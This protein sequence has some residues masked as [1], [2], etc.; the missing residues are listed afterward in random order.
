MKTFKNILEEVATEDDDDTAG[1]KQSDAD[2]YRSH[3]TDPG[4]S[5]L[6]GNDHVRMSTLV[7]ENKTSLLA[8]QHILLCQEPTSSRYS[9]NI[10]SI[11]VQ[12]RPNLWPTK[13]ALIVK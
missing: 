2:A 12:H 7:K 6:L 3:M 5:S 10:L 1:A 9:G 4:A 13:M 8:Y 11:M